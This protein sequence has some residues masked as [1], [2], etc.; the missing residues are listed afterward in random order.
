MTFTVNTNLSYQSYVNEDFPFFAVPESA[1]GPVTV[2]LSASVNLPTNSYLS[3]GRSGATISYWSDERWTVT[4]PVVDV[5]NLI[6]EIRWFPGP[7]F[8]SFVFALR[9]TDGSNIEIGTGSIVMNG[10]SSRPV[11][12]INPSTAV[13]E[14]NNNNDQFLD[15]AAPSD[16]SGGFLAAYIQLERVSSD[17]LF[18]QA[19]PSGGPIVRS[20]ATNYATF[21]PGFVGNARINTDNFIGI[22]TPATNISSGVGTTISIYPVWSVYGTHDEVS[23]AL[24]KLKITTPTVAREFNMRL[25]VTNNSTGLSFG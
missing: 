8:A 9:V 15:L 22:N 4:G 3:T 20:L 16:A 19:A 18:S 10:T 24:R 14:L 23:L 17:P 5:N 2:E 13:V 11:P 12:V 1:V 6:Q 25:Y 21:Y 7:T